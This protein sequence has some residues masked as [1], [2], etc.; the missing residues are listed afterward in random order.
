MGAW[1]AWGS[2]RIQPQF[3]RGSPL[4]FANRPSSPP[5]SSCPFGLGIR[6]GGGPGRNCHRSKGARKLVLKYLLRALCSPQPGPGSSKFLL[7]VLPPTS[8]LSKM[9]S[10]NRL[11]D[12]CGGAGG[13]WDATRPA[14][15]RGRRIL[16]G[17]LR[18][19]HLR[20]Y[21]AGFAP[22]SFTQRPPCP[23]PSCP[24]GVGSAC[25]AKSGE[26]GAQS[27]SLQRGA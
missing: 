11:G 18:S 26:S 25:E 22:V 2:P 17:D 20:P 19:P 6:G 5:V 14:P 16:H 3:A 4:G 12:P 8:R 23:A 10:R 21:F 27:P 9:P 7:P 24:L 15:G 1:G 13:S